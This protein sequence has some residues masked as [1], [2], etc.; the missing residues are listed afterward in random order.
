MAAG[1]DQYLG[2]AGAFFLSL[3]LVPQVVKTLRERS[4]HSSASFLAL[5]ILA[6]TCFILYGYL[7]PGGEG[8]PVVVS[9]AS[10]LLCTLVLVWAK[11]RFAVEG[12]REQ[13]GGAQERSLLGA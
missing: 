9:N 13:Q 12:A 3:V 7:L 8:L 11:V 5:E 1:A 6:S 4:D 2:Y 10:A